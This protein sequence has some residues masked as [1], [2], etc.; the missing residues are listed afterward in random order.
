MKLRFG[1]MMAHRSECDYFLFTGN[2]T[3][4]SNGCLVM[5]RGLAR[6]VRDAF[7]GV[8]LKLGEAIDQ[9]CYREA[10]S[11]TRSQTNRKYH[12]I[13]GQKLGV[14]QVKTRYDWP[15][16]PGLISDSLGVL[17]KYLEMQPEQTFFLNYPGIGNG[18]LA[19][20]D[21]AP[22]LDEHL[23]DVDNITIWER[24]PTTGGVA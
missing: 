14:L 2:S 24:K 8:D 10:S 22:L 4:K 18:Q 15:A 3:V 20:E 13:I 7:P 1:D 11:P 16:N 9:T 6:Q 21:V 19:R 12:L 23:G 17:R 5:G